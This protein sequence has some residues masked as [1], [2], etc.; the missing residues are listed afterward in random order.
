ME[1]E[2]IMTRTLAS[3]SFEAGEKRNNN[4]VIS[5]VKTLKYMLFK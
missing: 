4:N 3:Q 2:V 1:T 5:Y